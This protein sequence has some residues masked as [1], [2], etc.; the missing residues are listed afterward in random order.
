MINHFDEGAVKRLNRDS[1]AIAKYIAVLSHLRGLMVK[2]G[3]AIVADCGRTNF[4][5]NI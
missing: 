1:E 4:W 5:N 2:G 3:Y